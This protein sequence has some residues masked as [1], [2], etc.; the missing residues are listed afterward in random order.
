MP[1]LQVGGAMYHVCTRAARDGLLYADDID[2]QLF[3]LQVGRVVKRL[4]WICRAYC[5]MP[6]HYH[7]MI[8]TPEPDLAAGMHRIN[9]QYAVTFNRR[10]N[11]WGHVFQSRYRSVLVQSERHFLEVHR[12]IALNPVR[13]GLCRRPEDWPWS[14]YATMFG[15]VTPTPFFN[16]SA[17]LVGFEDGPGDPRDQLRSFVEAGLILEFP[18]AA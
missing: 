6:N 4:G 5:L 3:L 17:A 2:Y 15:G 13:A 8:E 14:S 10:H 12:Y 7:L 18:V 1:R 16:G 11:G 9:G